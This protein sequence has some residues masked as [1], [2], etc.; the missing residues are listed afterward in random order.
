MKKS[1]RIDFRYNLKIY[2]NFL[3]KYK[4]MFLA[5]TIL[6]LIGELINAS[7]K[8]L[9]KLIIDNGNDFTN[10]IIG[11][12]VFV[13]ILSIIAVVFIGMIIVKAF[14]KWFI[15]H[16]INKIESGVIY[17]IKQYFFNHIINLSHGFHT[18]HR[19]GSLIARL[20]RGAY[21]AERMTDF[22]VFNTF[23]ILFQM[24]ITSV[25]LLY[26]DWFSSI[27]V[28]ITASAF[29]IYGLAI[30]NIQKEANNEMNR[31]EDIEKANVADIFTNIDS[32]KYYGKE[33][34]IKNKFVRLGTNSKNSLRKFWDY[35]RWM[36][37]GQSTILVLGTFFLIF[38]SIKGFLS[39]NISIG[40]LTFIYTIYGSIFGNLYSFIH[41]IRNYYRA[42]VDFNDLFQYGKI[43]QEV[44]DKENALDIEIHKGKIEFKNVGFKYNER[45]IFNNFNLEIK[46][47][48]KVALVGH[49]GSGKTTLV[50]LLYRLYDLKDGNI[51]IEGIDVRDF[52]QERLRSELSIVPQEC[53]LFD[54]TI[55]NNI[56]FSKPDASREEVLRAMKF[57]QLDKIVAS[58]PKKEETIVGER[59]VRLSGGE[60]QRVSIARA[61]LANKKVI[62]LDEATSSLDSEAEHEIQRD[63]LELLKG[64]T[65]I[66]IAHRLSTIMHADKIVVLDKGK[67]VQTGKHNE[68]IRK[69]GLYKK[70][71]NL[72]KGGYLQD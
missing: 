72:Q 23:P 56:K 28:I 18:T 55:F 22:M 9:F 21:A 2:L 24:I 30:Q 43:K 57:A 17:D 35:F 33:E 58:F 31:N 39:G 46:H 49:S 44:K 61:I 11:A 37:A 29:I 63:L 69:Q 26:F 47:G 13:E 51:E 50:K 10:K 64:R 14:S 71:W 12:S 48:E 62:V 32:I 65:S 4:W 42:M 34:F 41:G 67:I 6:I 38:F 40:T 45:N 59:G 3:K 66:I 19:T 1:K 5:V 16:Y 68:L 53:V 7:E 70:L 52:K 25:S 8:Y 60:K 54:D 20:G 36:D 27:I 15:L